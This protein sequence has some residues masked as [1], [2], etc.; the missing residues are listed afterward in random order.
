[1]RVVLL[2]LATG[3]AYHSSEA[4]D[5]MRDRESLFAIDGVTDRADCDATYDFDNANKLSLIPVTRVS[6]SVVHCASI[7]TRHVWHAVVL[8]VASYNVLSR[9]RGVFCDIQYRSADIPRQQCSDCSTEQDLTN[10]GDPHILKS[11][12]SGSQ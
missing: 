7:K 5:I 2:F 10:L 3:E 12:F 4:K 6:M 8:T 11:N 9:C 1:M